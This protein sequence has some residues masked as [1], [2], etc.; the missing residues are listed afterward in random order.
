[1]ENNNFTSGTSATFLSNYKDDEKA[2]AEAVILAHRDA[3]RFVQ[4]V[5]RVPR[6]DEPS[7]FDVLVASYTNAFLLSRLIK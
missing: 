2:M 6:T 4:Q 7:T 3:E 5:V 1:M